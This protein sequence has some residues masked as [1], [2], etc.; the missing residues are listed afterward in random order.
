MKRIPDKQMSIPG[1]PTPEPKVIKPTTNKQGL[2]SLES[3]VLTLELE[4]YLL[5]ILVEKGGKE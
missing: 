3:R 4:V 1:L 2:A 5:R